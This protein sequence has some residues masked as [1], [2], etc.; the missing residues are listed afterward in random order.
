MKYFD[1][2]ANAFHEQTNAIIIPETIN[3]ETGEIIPSY[4]E[5]LDELW[6]EIDDEKVTKLFEQAIAENK[7]ICSDENGYPILKTLEEF[8]SL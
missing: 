4:I 3:E 2:K 7:V 5:N 1:K 6:V 8:I